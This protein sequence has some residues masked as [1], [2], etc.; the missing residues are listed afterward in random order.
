VELEVSAAEGLPLFEIGTLLIR[1]SIRL[2]GRAI[3]PSQAT[4]TE[5]E[6]P[7]T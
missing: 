2:V 4:Y 1:H 3:C 5:K 7:Q 6:N